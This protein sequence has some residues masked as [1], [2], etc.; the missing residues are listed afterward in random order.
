VTIIAKGMSDDWR[1]AVW[2]AAWYLER[3][4]RGWAVR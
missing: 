4:G 2:Y 1:A 3:W